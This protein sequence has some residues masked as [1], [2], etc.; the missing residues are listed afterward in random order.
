MLKKTN[1]LLE[2]LTR[3]QLF[4]LGLLL[5]LLVLWPLF[6][7][8]FFSH[9]DDVSVIRLY[10]MHKCFQDFQIP[11]RWVPD[12]GGGYGYPLFNYYPPLPY[13][14]GEVVY[15][16]TANFL[17]SVKVLFAAS[18]LLSFSTMF[19]LAQAHWGKWSGF[20]AGIF[21]TFAPYHAADLYV[22]GA[23]G[24]LWAF[25][26]IP[27][28]FWSVYKAF[29][30]NGLI[31]KLYFPV[32]IALLV[33]SHNISALVVIPAAIAFG[34]L[35]GRKNIIKS[36]WLMILLTICGLA[37]S[38]F[39]WLPALVEKNLVHTESLTSGYFYFTEHF[40]GLRKL[41]VPT[42]WNW[43]PSIR[44]IPGG[45]RDAQW[46]QLGLVHWLTLFLV[47]GYSGVTYFKKHKKDNDL[48][49]VGFIF[50][51]FSLSVFMVHPRSD[52][53]WKALPLIEFMQFPWRF[54]LVSAFA[55]AFASGFLA[56]ILKP[57]TLFIVVMA[58]ILL[59]FSKFIP[60][61]FITTSDEEYLH[62]ETFRKQIERSIFDYLPIYLDLPPSQFKT[63][64]FTVISG[65]IT[66]T[67]FRKGTDW[68]NFTTSSIQGG[69][70]QLSQYY[71]P[72]WT[73]KLNSMPYDITFDNT[74]ALIT[75]NVPAG[76][77]MFSLQ[78][79]NTPVRLVA[80]Y[81]SVISLL[82]LLISVTKLRKSNV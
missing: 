56:K 24:E 35:I 59:N 20:L 40:K 63:Q 34:L 21:Y 74:L 62:G 71:F 47:T 19:L 10:Q 82:G 39:Y 17:I 30:E 42:T 33:L 1:K 18:I 81:L 5:S 73:A 11:C 46:Y 8:P 65:D 15:L 29:T 37:L 78:L 13:Y 31:N 7:A 69:K 72:K 52:F 55:M 14:L 41:F 77:S 48:L 51:L 38:S 70:I 68:I 49:V 44:E 36:F 60:E 22:R 54:L 53:I 25:V 12:L 66:V 43:G 50:L 4:L 61:K 80:N 3:G 64:E 79:T 6:A 26:F 76:E 28:L 75:V 67:D 57:T 45:E 32:T 2:K 27:L 58:V 23:M 9:H 16:I